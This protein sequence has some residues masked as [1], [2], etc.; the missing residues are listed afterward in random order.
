M[1]HRF[2]KMFDFRQYCNPCIKQGS[3]DVPKWTNHGLP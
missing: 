1:A 3:N 2:D